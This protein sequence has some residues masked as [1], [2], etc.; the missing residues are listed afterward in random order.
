MSRHG[1]QDDYDC[2]D[3]D[4]DGN[5]VAGSATAKWR[6]ALDQE[7]GSDHGQRL[8]REMRDGLEA[9]PEKRLIREELINDDGECCAL[10]GVA[11]LR[12]MDVSGIDPEDPQQVAKAFGISEYLAREIA[13][14]NDEW[15]DYM[16]PEARWR[17]MRSWCES[18]IKAT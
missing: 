5:P 4:E 6:E 12:G 17:H 13:F 3:Y 7:I 16:T 2:E 10:G 1:Y 18:R 14:E 15:S 11:K 9:I 8:L